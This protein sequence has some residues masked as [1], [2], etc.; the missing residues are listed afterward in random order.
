MFIVSLDVM[1]GKDLILFNYFI[2]ITML[3]LCR[4]IESASVQQAFHSVVSDSLLLHG[5]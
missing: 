1:K 3:L 5:L 2:M 4:S